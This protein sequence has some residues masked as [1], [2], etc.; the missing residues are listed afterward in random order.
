MK[1]IGLVVAT[2]AAVSTAASFAGVISANAGGLQIAQAGV[3]VQVGRDRDRDRDRYRD[4][5]R[6]SRDSGVTIGVG[7]G[8][9][10]V[11]PRERC[12]TV[13]TTVQRDDGRTVTR[14][15]RQCD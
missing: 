12:R 7:P 6:D 5:H 10:R 13:T 15:E 4:E 2:A 11:G 14:K 1:M 3:D 8:G 9:V